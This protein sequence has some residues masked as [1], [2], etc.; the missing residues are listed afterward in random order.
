MGGHNAPL[1]ALAYDRPD[2]QRPYTARSYNWVLQLLENNGVVGLAFFVA[3]LVGG[4]MAAYRTARRPEVPVFRRQMGV[5]VVAGVAAV[6]VRDLTYTSVVLHSGAMSL[7]WLMLGVAVTAGQMGEG[8]GEEKPLPSRAL[9]SLA[10]VAAMSAGIIFLPAYSAGS[11]Y[12][13]AAAA[14]AAGDF[15]G[16]VRPLELAEKREP[17]NAIFPA[18]RGLALERSVAPLV[19]VQDLH[20]PLHARVS[21]QPAIAAAMG[22]YRRAL[23]LSPNDAAFHHNLG[24]LCALAGQEECAQEELARAVELDG[25][26]P[27]YAVSLGLYWERRGR[28][29]RALPWYAEA[30]AVSPSLVDSEFFSDLQDRY[31]DEVA[32]VLQRAMDLLVARAGSPLIPTYLGKLLEHTGKWQEARS[33]VEQGLSQVPNLPRAWLTLGEID[34]GTGAP[35][36]SQLCY[37]RA[38]FLAKASPE[39][40]AKLADSYRAGGDAVRAFTLYRRSAAAPQWSV[41]ASRVE[42]LYHAGGAVPDDIVPSRLLQYCAPVIATDT[43]GRMA[44]LASSLKKPLSAGESGR[45]AFLVLSR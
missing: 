30:V 19:H 21:A 35:A 3:I 23:W 43:C 4:L 26:E 38:L 1:T 33:Q 29:E 25:S 41:H 27:V 20:L 37:R 40:L 5:L 13:Q 34:A 31:P 32:G 42:R 16:A 2:W 6:L 44:Q 9:A 39:T 8:E 18:T 14:L 10:A 45:C 7:V 12:A 28:L 24:W 22:A 36:A 17:G 11:Y 15:K